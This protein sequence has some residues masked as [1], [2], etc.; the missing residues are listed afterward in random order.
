MRCSEPLILIVLAALA[1]PLGAQ[2]P[3]SE[4]PV[5]SSGDRTWALDAGLSEDG[6]LVA[7]RA[8]DGGV[9]R[10]FVRNAFDDAASGVAVTPEGTAVSWWAWAPEAR[11]IVFRAEGDPRL[12]SVPLTSDE[13]DG[14]VDP[15]SLRDLTYETDGSARL[16]GF[17]PG[18][19]DALV[20]VPGRW[21]D[22]PDLIRV[23]L[24]SGERT[25]VAT[26]DGSIHRWI[27]DERGEPRL[28]IRPGGDEE[29]ELVRRRGE[30]FLPIYRCEGGET[31]EPAGFH[32]DGRIWLRTDRG[33]DRL[34][35]VLLDPLTAEEE[36]VRP[37]LTGDPEAVFRSDSLF[38]EAV[39]RVA[40]VAGDARLTFHRSPGHG[41]RVMVTAENGNGATAFLHDR[42]SGE[43]IRILELDPGAR[44]GLRGGVAPPAPDPEVLRA[45]RLGYRIT[46]DD[47]GATAVEMERRIDER[48]ERGR[49]VWQV[50]DEAEVPTYDPLDLDLPDLSDDPEMEPDP[51]EDGLTPTGR[52]RASDTTILDGAS[53]APIRRRAEGPLS[54]RL[55]FEDGRVVGAVEVG[56]F[57]TPVDR[58]LEAPAWTEGA[59]MEML[60]AALPLETGYRTSFAI[61]QGEEAELLT[62]ELAVGEG[63]Q[64]TTPA[65]AFE[66][67][68]LTIVSDP[69]GGIDEEWLVLGSAPHY[70]VR[71]VV[72]IDGL[73]RTTE[74]ID[75]G[76]LR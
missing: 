44:A 72:R 6:R 19:A 67:L 46:E 31:C 40:E 34:A 45:V 35:L 17:G 62:V 76:G 63:D 42:W 48:T 29:T 27:P 65:G 15:G 28:A 74:L 18:P 52:T 70:L 53:L 23:S 57:E 37:D 56:G 30:G 22:A 50:V 66:V 11:H 47:P 51:F 33:R 14:A 68:R 1:A 26:N 10:L 12:H 32:P 64:V 61:L 75:A 8:L 71:A 5:P 13:P 49:R 9:V 16:A 39:E 36:E 21:P 7:F 58:E 2:E 55:D 25:T 59:A 60:V 54:I 24:E 73:T 69:A 41:P 38:H 3:T 4:S 43:V 20:E